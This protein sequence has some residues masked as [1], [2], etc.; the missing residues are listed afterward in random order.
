MARDSHP[1]LKSINGL[2][3]SSDVGLIKYYRFGLFAQELR[4]FPLRGD[5]TQPCRGLK[6]SIIVHMLRKSKL[7]IRAFCAIVVRIALVWGSLP[8]LQRLYGGY[9]NSDVVQMKYYPF[10][11][12]RNRFEIR[13][14]V[15]FA[16]YLT[17]K[18]IMQFLR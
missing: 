13:P 11:L 3:Y 18:F 15:G 4:K 5:R 14:V 16:S 10:A 8:T 17:E 6:A 7:S 9:Y 1:A 2:Y 12:L